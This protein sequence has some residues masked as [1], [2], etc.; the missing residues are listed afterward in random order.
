[1]RAHIRV[2]T[3]A[4]AILLAETAIAMAQTPTTQTIECTG[5]FAKDV[6]HEKLVTAFGAANVVFEDVDGAEGE[7]I[8]ASVIFPRDPARRVE[9]IWG[10]EAKRTDP[11]IRIQGKSGWIA[12]FGIRLGT[13]VE[14][15]EKINGKPFVVSGFG[16]DYGGTVTDWKGGKLAGQLPGGCVMALMF[17][18][19]PN[20]PARAYRQVSGDSVQAPSN[21]P[22]IRA[23][24]PFVSAISLS[25]PP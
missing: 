6:T 15:V 14:E 10:N 1:M 8:K 9:F 3:A 24:K 20:P 19:G 4:A 16:W 23:V 13:P 2:L 22:N 5:V 11:L 21:S 17:E 18:V 12:P 25:F 7:K